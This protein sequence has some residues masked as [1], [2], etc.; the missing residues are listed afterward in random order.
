MGVLAE[1]GCELE[2]G[3]QHGWLLSIASSG[4]GLDAEI[5]PVLLQLGRLKV[6]PSC[7]SIASCQKVH[8]ESGIHAALSFKNGGKIHS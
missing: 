5:L 3:G 1:E 7:N 4:T 8:N 2:G 6:V